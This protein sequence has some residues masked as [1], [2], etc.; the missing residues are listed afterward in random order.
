MVELVTMFRSFLHNC[1]KLFNTVG[2]E[3]TRDIEAN[4]IGNVETNYSGKT[5]WSPEY[6][7]G[8]DKRWTRDIENY[9]P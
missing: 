4:V 6:K 1:W 3:N 2:I 8:F 7:D 5:C 9:Y